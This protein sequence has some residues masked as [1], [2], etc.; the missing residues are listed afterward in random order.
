MRFRETS[1]GI[2]RDLAISPH[3]QDLRR[4]AEHRKSKHRQRRPQGCWAAKSVLSRMD[5]GADDAMLSCSIFAV[6]RGIL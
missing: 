4:S 5:Q 3:E 6:F 1:E 2:A